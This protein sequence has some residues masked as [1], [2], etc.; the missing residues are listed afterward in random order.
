M[1][2]HLMLQHWMS[3]LWGSL[4]LL[5]LLQDQARGDVKEAGLGSLL[6]PERVVVPSYD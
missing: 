1:E 4:H 2:Q 5:L 3:L 6:L